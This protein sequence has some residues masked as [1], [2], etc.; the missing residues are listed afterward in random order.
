MKEILED[1]RDL[2]MG[3]VGTSVKRG[4]NFFAYNNP[5]LSAVS[6]FRAQVSM[7]VSCS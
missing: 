6:L 5:L 3:L 1:T 4:L 7:F 2:A